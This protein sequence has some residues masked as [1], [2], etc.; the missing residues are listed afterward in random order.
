[1][2][3]EPLGVPAPRIDPVD[4]AILSSRFTAIVRKMSNTLV[5]AGRSV[6][7]NTGRDFSCCVITG[8]DEL[9]AM[10]E[11]VPTHVLSGPDLMAK[12]MRAFH[13]DLKPGDAFL[14]NSPYHGNSH[15]ADLSILV[16]VFDDEG[17][18]RFTVLS[19]AHL[20]D[21]GNAQPTAYSAMARDVY[22]EGALIFPCVQVQQNYSD[23]ADVIRMCRMRIR[24]PD[25][26][27]G[28]YLALLGSARVGEREVRL[29]A[30]EIGWDRIEAFIRAWFDYSEMLIAEAIDRLPEG[31]IVVTSCH[32]PFERV[33]DGIPVK[34]RIRVADGLIDVDLTDNVDCQPCGLNTTEATAR[35][36][37]MLGVFNAINGYAPPNA[38]SFRRL[39]VH[40]R[41]N[42]VV[43]IPRHPASCSV[44]TCNL[45]DRIG[46]AVQRGLAELADGYGLAE[47]GLSQPASVSV[48]SGRDA[49][50]NNEPFVD[51]LTL[52]WTGGAGGPVADG[53]L[54][55]GGIGDAGVLQRDSVELDELRFPIRVETQ[56]IVADTEGAGRRRGAPA[57]EAA[58][59]ATD[60]EFEVIYLSDGT[61]NPPLGARGGGPGARAWQAIRR[62]N[63]DIEE[64]GLCERLTIRQGET[65]L[66]RCCGGGGYGNPREREPERVVAD[67]QEGFVSRERAR[68]VYGVEIDDNMRL[69]L[70]ATDAL[71]RAA[72]PQL[73]GAWAR[74]IPTRPHRAA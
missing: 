36:A 48:F 4:L 29:L 59:T 62:A 49:R 40:V 64:V 5:R 44:A 57:A 72:A 38:G 27:W 37:A 39:R 61:V 11:S 10:A 45:P 71:R 32:D 66:S 18:H 68:G 24:I 30:E 14:H 35:S 3:T 34:V 60:G 50:R 73:D 55:M 33:P 69:D 28:D 16:P 56:R 8:T 6:I 9:L 21:I 43:G 63:G 17:H 20:A 19:K 51:Q 41:E 74:P 67:V 70:S 53:W 7:L 47:V 1:V 42:C 31:E 52:G 23:I 2:L 26:W 12:S 46:N 13:L 65:I 54:T 22:E 25:M 15:P 58:I